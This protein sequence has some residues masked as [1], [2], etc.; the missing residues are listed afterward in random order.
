[1]SMLKMPTTH[2]FI[3]F[4][5]AAFGTPLA[6]LAQERAITKQVLVMDAAAKKPL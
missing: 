6:A 4:L 2:W 3:V 1:M 5:A